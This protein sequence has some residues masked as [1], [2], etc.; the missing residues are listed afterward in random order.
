MLCR[1][2]MADYLSEANLSQLLVAAVKS[3]DVTS[4]SELLDQGANVNVQDDQDLH[5]CVEY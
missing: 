4:V 2:D 1:I 3:G 5:V